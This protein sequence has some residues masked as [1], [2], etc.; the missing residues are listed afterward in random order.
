MSSEEIRP[1][2][3]IAVSSLYAASYDQAERALPDPQQ[4][5]RQASSR[6]SS[7]NRAHVAEEP[8][9]TLYYI[10]YFTFPILLSLQH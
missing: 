9:G 8:R 1:P 2:V 7:S 10:G 4:A 5:T 3:P 6:S